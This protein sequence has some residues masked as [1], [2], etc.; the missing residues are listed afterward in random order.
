MFL[1]DQYFPVVYGLAPPGRL[2]LSEQ[3]NRL[4]PRSQRCQPLPSR[5]V[6]ILQPCRALLGHVSAR[7]S[8]TDGCGSAPAALPTH[9]GTH[10]GAAPKLFKFSF[11]LFCLSANKL[12]PQPCDW[13]LAKLQLW[14]QLAEFGLVGFF[15]CNLFTYFPSQRRLEA[16]LL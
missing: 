1:F 5:C 11:I 9:P 10:P 12:A 7:G 2:P 13:L 8:R 6:S 15:Y 4:G 3:R 14:A 16:K